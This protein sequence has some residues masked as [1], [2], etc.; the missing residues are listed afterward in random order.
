MNVTKDELIKKLTIHN[1]KIEIEGENL[2]TGRKITIT[3]GKLVETLNIIISGDTNGDGIISA[4]DYVKIKNHIMA[5]SKLEGAYLKAAD[6]NKDG[7]IS[8]VDYVKIKN[9]IMGDKAQIE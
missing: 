5:T 6:V 3:S 2:A 4:V 9:Y 7:N 8:A 1:A